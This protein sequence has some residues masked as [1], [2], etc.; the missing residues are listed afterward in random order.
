[1]MFR[2]SNVICNV[3]FSMLACFS[4]QFIILA[5]HKHIRINNFQFNFN[6]HREIHLH[7]EM[8]EAQSFTAILHT[9]HDRS[10]PKETI[11]AVVKLVT[12]Q[13]M[14]DDNQNERIFITD[15]S[16]LLY[17]TVADDAAQCKSFSYNDGGFI[18][19]FSFS[20]FQMLMEAENLRFAR[21]ETVFFFFAVRKTKSMELNT[22]SE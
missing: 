22:A 17:R 2:H 3:A 9:F 15:I 20:S 13:L 11:L 19:I 12:M 5:Y 10:I 8:K 6:S 21:L 7:I 16:L 18:N 4:I 1:M 14:I